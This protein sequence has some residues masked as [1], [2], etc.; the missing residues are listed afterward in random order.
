MKI[1]KN[2]L[3]FL[4]FGTI[5]FF[6]SSLYSL[7]E[8][9]TFAKFKNPVFVE[10]GAHVGGG[11]QRALSSGFKE[12]HSI[13][14][15]PT[16]YRNCKRKYAMRK[17]VHLHLGDSGVILYDVIKNINSPITFWLDG[18][19]MGEGTVVGNSK[20]PIIAELEHI[21]RHHIKTHTILIDDVRLFGTHYFD[22]LTLEEVIQK[23]VEINPDY[24]ISYVDGYAKND[25][26]VARV[27]P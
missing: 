20:T 26:L 10:T 15:D 2:I 24:K 5:F 23:I 9:G 1:A 4:I 17:N 19:H 7:S 11:I 16:H 25:I 21:K 12:V 27:K 13:E 14:L 8:V 18:H 6:S 3:S 22:F